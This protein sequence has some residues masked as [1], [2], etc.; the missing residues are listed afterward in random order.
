MGR[1]A[2]NKVRK[3]ENHKTE[4]WI[5]QI[6]PYLQVNGLKGITMDLVAKELKKSKATL[7]EY[8]KSKETLLDAVIIY[9]L[10]EIKKFELIIKDKSLSFLEKYNGI[11]QH[12][13]EN[14]S[15]ISNLFLTDLRD[16]FPKLWQKI[17]SF[18]DYISKVM[19]DFYNE[20]IEQGIFNE[21]NTGI[22]VMHDQLFFRMLTNPDFLS[23]EKLTLETAYNQYLKLKFFGLL[24]K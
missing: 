8:F 14:V 24:K 22:L 11:L 6:F 21:I 20:G 15:D 9:K 7:Y 13:A 2:T 17:E 16:L 4:E 5:K 3:K 10:D 18:L 12:Q 19:E 23:K 1:K